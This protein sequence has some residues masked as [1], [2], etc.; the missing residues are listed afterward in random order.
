MRRRFIQNKK[1]SLWTPFYIEALEDGVSFSIGDEV[2]Y[3]IDDG[4]WISLGSNINSE[5]INKGSRLYIKGQIV[6]STSYEN[7][8]S[9][10]GLCK[11]GG[12]IKSLSFGEQA[13]KINKIN[14]SQF[15]FLFENCTTIKEV[16][17]D[18][19]L[20][21]T[22]DQ[23][24]FHRMFSG[25]T[26]LVKV[27]NLPAVTLKE[28]CYMS[29]FA[30]CT[31]LS[32]IK[33]LATD[34]SAT[35]C[36]NGWVHGVSSTGTFVKNKDAKWNT[37][38]GVLGN[39]GV[40]TG[41]TVVNDGEDVKIITFFIQ[42]DFKNLQFRSYQTEEGMTW[43]EW[44]NSSYNTEGYYLMETSERTVVLSPIIE[45]LGLHTTDGVP[46]VSTD[47]I[48]EGYEYILS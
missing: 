38:P 36:L 7:T 28:R 46:V 40:P 26:S 25:C 35:D 16:L 11:I 47:V 45:G 23:Q 29:M 4:G 24:C 33:M 22:L 15:Q 8:F 41:W 20:I 44:V 3:K 21:T 43:E 10:Q 1:E 39:S 18:F 9:I 6:N 19:H 13:K 27:H 31:N 12:D 42:V 48:I 34:I 5:S 30:G 14:D 32:Y 2:E 37:T 17:I